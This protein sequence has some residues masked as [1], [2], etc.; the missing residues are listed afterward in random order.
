M[1]TKG[2]VTLDY[3]VRLV[4]MDLDDYSLAFYKKY[5]Q[6]AILGF[7][8]VNLFTIQS[9]RVAYLP[10]NQNTKS[11][12]LP[13]DFIMYSKI[14]FNKGGELA[15]FSIN[16]DLMLTRDTDSCG[17]LLNDNATG[18]DSG[19][20]PF[21]NLEYYTP[22]YRNGQFVGEMFGGTGNKNADGEFRIDKELRK[23][24]FGSE[25]SASEIILEYKSSG[26][27]GDGSTVVPREYIEVLRAYV[28][29]QRKEYNDKMAQSEKDRLR[30]RYTDEFEK[31]RNLEF[32][33]TIEE[34]YDSTRSTY[35]Q[36]PKR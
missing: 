33:F 5:L 7:Q 35:K 14:G 26:V 4:L 28:H 31:V 3:I 10:L 15:T 2:I 27:S 24:T 23:I 32:S 21:Y 13:D 36:S 9:L 6:Y 20:G 8:D 34:Y 16:K 17:N 22:H 1:D 19:I 29:W 30:R 18:Q 12:D 11:V 25:V